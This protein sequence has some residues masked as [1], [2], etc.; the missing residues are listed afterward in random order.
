MHMPRRAI[1]VPLRSEKR[2]R[3][4]IARPS[5]DT[6]CPTHCTT[7]LGVVRLGFYVEMWKFMGME[8]RH[9]V[10]KPWIT[11]SV[12]MVSCLLN[13]NRRCFVSIYVAQHPRRTRRQCLP[14]IL[15][16]RV[17]PLMAVSPAVVCPVVILHV[18]E[19][20]EV[21]ASPR[22]IIQYVTD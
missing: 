1:A 8:T 9:R 18:L 17:A 3:R 4:R 7:I 20:V 12:P 11:V 15:Q 5:D 2:L 21:E 6:G 14:R 16:R 13:A 10:R 22:L 19:K